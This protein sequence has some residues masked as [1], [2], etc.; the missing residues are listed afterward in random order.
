MDRQRDIIK[1]LPE[2]DSRQ[3]RD[4]SVCLKSISDKSEMQYVVM[5]EK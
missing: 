3:K 2:L 5:E 1:G 4:E